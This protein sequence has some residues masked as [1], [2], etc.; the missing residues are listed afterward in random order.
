MLLCAFVY[1]F[2]IGTTHQRIGSGNVHDVVSDVLHYMI[3]IRPSITAYVHIHNHVFHVVAS[4]LCDAISEENLA[5]QA[6]VSVFF[7]KKAI[8]SDLRCH[9]PPTCATVHVQDGNGPA[10]PWTWI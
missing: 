6:I 4:S 2:F 9:P 3:L 7:K 5:I 1:H 8:M 10:L